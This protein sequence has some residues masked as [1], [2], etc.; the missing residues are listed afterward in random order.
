MGEAL[1]SSAEELS[2]KGAVGRERVRQLHDANRNAATLVEAI[3]KR[4]TVRS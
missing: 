1:R 2:A 3:A 4:R